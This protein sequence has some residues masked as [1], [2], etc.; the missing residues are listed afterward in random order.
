MPGTGSV[1]MFLDYLT[2]LGLGPYICIELRI[3]IF[4]YNY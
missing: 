1:C 2:I 4:K 3:L